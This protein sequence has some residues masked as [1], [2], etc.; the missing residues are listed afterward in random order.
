MPDMLSAPYRRPP[1]EA[2]TDISYRNIFTCSM[3]DLFGN[4]V[5]KE[6][7]EAVLRVVR[8]NPQW[9]FLFLT[10]FP[11]RMTEFEY[12]DNAWLGTTVDLQARVPNAERATRPPSARSLRARQVRPEQL[13][14]P[15]QK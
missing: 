1:S 8:E 10:K 3:A 13:P 9:N 6:W 12:P 7:I 11:L 4:W 14:V 5:P 15:S 2:A